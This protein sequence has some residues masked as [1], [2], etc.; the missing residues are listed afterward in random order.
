M[1]WLAYKIVWVFNQMC[2]GRNCNE[3][4]NLELVVKSLARVQFFSALSGRI[5]SE[6]SILP[7]ISMLNVSAAEASRYNSFKQS[8]KKVFSSN[9]YS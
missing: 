5:P 2:N 7:L 1:D 3:N 9:Y 4:C 6:V 8:V